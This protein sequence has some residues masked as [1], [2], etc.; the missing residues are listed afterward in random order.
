MITKTTGIARLGA[1]LAWSAVVIGALLI[2]L[3]STTL[4][5][6]RPGEVE[7]AALPPVP[8]LQILRSDDSGVVLELLVPDYRLESIE[9]DG[10]PYEHLTVDGLASTSKAGWPRLPLASALLAVP[11]DAAVTVR[12]LSDEAQ[13]VAGSHLLSPAPT[14]APS[15]EDLQP[16]EW[17]L[18]PDDTAYASSAVFPSVVARLADDAWLRDQR[19]VRVELFPFQFQPDAR[20]LTWHRRLRVAVNFERTGREPFS[21]ASDVSAP[22]DAMSRGSLLNYEQA[23]AWRADRPATATRPTVDLTSRTKIVVDHDGLYR[24]TYADLLAAGVNVTNVVPSALRL[25]SQQ[26]A[27]AIEVTGDADG[28]FDPGDSIL[29]YGQKLRGDVLAARYA[30]ESDN[31]L[32]FNNGWRPTFNAQMVELYSD[33]N[34]Y[35]L[36]TSGPAG[37]R[38]STSNGLPS[39]TAAVPD[40]YTATVHAEKVNYWRTTTFSSVDVFFWDWF[41]VVAPATRTYTTTLS[42]VA[43]GQLSATVRAEI[44]PFTT[45]LHRVRL[46][47]GTPLT[48]LADVSWSGLVRQRLTGQLS[49]TLLANGPFTATINVAVADSVYFDWFEIDYARRFEAESGQLAF[50]ANQVGPREYRVGQLLTDTV[51]V[52]DITNPLLPR[53]IL[54]PVITSGG[55][56]FTASFEVTHTS[57]VTYIVAGAD[58][59]QSPKAI[60]FYAPT[61]L[62]GGVGADYVIIAPRA[63]I[64]AVQPLADYRSAQGLRTRVINVDDLYNQYNDGI[65]HPIAIKNFLRDAYTNW[66]KPAPAYALLVGDGHWNFKGYKITGYATPAT[67]PIYMPPNLNWVD[68]WQGEVDSSSYLAAVSG[69]D[70]LPDLYIGRLPVNSIAELNTMISKTLGFEQA[71][72]QP[73][74]QRVTFV[75]DNIPDPAGA[76]DFIASSEAAIAYV[77][78]AY[79]IDRIYENDFGCVSLT[80]C[81]AVNYALT[82]TLNLTGALFVNYTG[83][84][85]VNR[86]SHEN[87]F[88]NANIATLTN[89]SQ[90]PILLSMTCL[91]GYWTHALTGTSSSLVELNVRAANGGAVAAFS[92]TGLGVANGHD[93]LEQGFFTAVFANGVQRLGPAALAAKV[94]LYGTGSHPDLIHTFT[95]FGDPALKLP[96]YALS[97][98]PSADTRTGLI[99]QV[100]TYTLRLTNSAFMTDAVSFSAV[101]RTWPTVLPPVLNLPPGASAQVVVSVTVPVTATAGRTERIT[102]TAQ[103]TGDATRID[104]VLTT[105]FNR[106]E[107]TGAQAQFGNPGQVLTYPLLLS[108]M[109]SLTD[110]FALDMSGQAW[111]ASLSAYSATLP[112]GTNLLVTAQVTIPVTA[113]VDQVDLALVQAQ[114]ANTGLTS[115]VNFTSTVNMLHQATLNPITVSSAGS[116]GQVVTYPFQLHNTGSVTLTFGI[117]G[118]SAWPLSIAPGTIGLL[119]PGVNVPF[120]V[121]TTIP[122]TAMNSVP[123][124]ITVTEQDSLVAPLIAYITTD[125]SVVHGVSLAAQPTVLAAAPENSATYAISLTN[126]GNVHEAFTLEPLGGTWPISVWPT[127]LLVPPGTTQAAALTVTVPAQTLANAA[128]VTRLA[129]WSA[130]RQVSA[131]LDVTTTASAVYGV[132]ISPSSAAQTARR[133]ESITYTLRLTNTGNSATS[134]LLTSSGPWVTTLSPTLSAPVAAFG[135]LDVK[136]AVRVPITAPIGQ[137]TTVVTATAQG[138]S[139]PF[140]AATLT[141]TVQNYRLYLPVVRRG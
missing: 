114:S 105:Y 113:V 66:P 43:A 46:L 107:L 122:V 48:Q 80:P 108:N 141:T 34:V 81:P 38:M 134:F 73:Y 22:F 32:T 71:G 116:P 18:L 27:V 25:T 10:Q 136:V 47:A 28:H 74:Q 56:V 88:V 128:N 44:A 78:P 16:G 101:S 82:Q 109:G 12:V 62:S 94:Q 57:P 104:S 54:S 90:L 120:T 15:S 14:A 68:P 72:I 106:H 85:S 89:T 99:G 70:I 132:Q 60:S 102:V 139:Q 49:Q 13:T 76:G 53:R 33:E 11:P 140:V 119:T 130:G 58:Q 19:V 131:T 127:V 9:I 79:T 111:P 118:Q 3:G 96:T 40:Y 126:S 87:I 26:Q 103:S 75:A 83:H 69:G 129:G 137:A 31:W 65:Y 77:S 52:L 35:W 24:L 138:G 135:G 36:T 93:S 110:S 51:T 21:S 59:V 123:A 121:T 115:G 98:T 100:L 30:A 64:T 84:G 41:N 4:A 20:K 2:G 55:G 133:G 39:G 23:R 6:A 124:T 125:S 92:P 45:N 117:S 61:D 17:Q 97:M 7:Q 1:V 37:T 8:G 91:D 95:T 42:A 29:F 63:F 50:K 86:W 67:D 5:V 112:P